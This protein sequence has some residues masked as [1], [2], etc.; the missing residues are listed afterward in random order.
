M[1]EHG[2]P[3]EPRDASTV[4]VV[5]ES[6]N[7]F[8]EMFCVERHRRSAFMGGALVFPGGK[9]DPSDHADTW[10]SLA[11]QL[12]PRPRAFAADEGTARAFAVAAIREA[13]EEA[14]IVPV[15]GDRVDASLAL[16]LRREI[17]GAPARS[18][19][20]A[21]HARGLVLDVGR[22]QALARWITPTAE[23]KRFDTRFYLL[24]LPEGQ[25]GAHDDHET[26]T[27]FWATPA[28][29]LS[30]WERGEVI[31][32]PPTAWTLG[33]FVGLKSVAAAMAVAERTSL[34]PI[35]P[36]FMEDAGVMILTLPGDP[37]HPV[38]SPPPDN[39]GAPTRFV[40]EG[41]RFVPRRV[42]R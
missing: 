23:P 17:S 21:L 9:V 18:L 22:L 42:A 32:A 33:L 1:S 5:R 15:T 39:P 26:T 28:E 20:D 24:P 36:C 11:T 34:S 31:L 25:A 35:E 30:R 38:N 8:L 6:E 7:G 14:A 10:A 29:V 40:L 41:S 13:L 27:S 12:A 4:V 3:A 37:L 16:E 2:R 19:A